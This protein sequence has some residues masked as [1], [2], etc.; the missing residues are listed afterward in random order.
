MRHGSDAFFAGWH[1]AHGPTWENWKRALVVFFGF[2]SLLDGL[3]PIS[4][5]RMI[6][7][8]FVCLFPQV[9]KGA[10]VLSSVVSL[11]SGPVLVCM[12][13]LCVRNNNRNHLICR[14]CYVFKYEKN[15]VHYRSITH[16]K[17]FIHKQMGSIQCAHCTFFQ[18]NLR[19]SVSIGHFLILCELQLFDI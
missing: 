6:F 4:R 1:G 9:E 16:R 15:H 5:P 18:L 10:E 12:C 8:L 11:R 13:S 14:A 19:Q 2:G 7:N 3:D 17:T